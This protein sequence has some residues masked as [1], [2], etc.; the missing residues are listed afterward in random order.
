ASQALAAGTRAQQEM[1]KLRNDLRNQTSSQFAEQMRQMRN[2]ARELANKEDEI[3]R[4]MESLN[5]PGR[6]SLD[7]SA[8]RKQVAE[9]MDNQQQAL[10]NLLSNMQSVSQQAESTEPLLSQQLYDTLRHAN[11]LHTD[12]LLDAGAQM[13]ERGLLPQAAEAESAARTNI[14]E[15]RQKIE[16]AAESVLGN[17]ADTL[18]YAQKELDDLANRLERELNQGQP[19]ASGTARSKMGAGNS[20]EVA[21]SQQ[22]NGG[23]KSTN[24]QQTAQSSEKN[25]EKGTNSVAE[26]GSRGQGRQQG[27]GKN[28]ASRGQGGQQAGQNPQSQ[29]QGQANT[30][31]NGNRAGQ[32]AGNSNQD[33]QRDNQNNR[34]GGS[35]ENPQASDQQTGGTGDNS[36]GA[37]TVAGNDAE[38]LSEIVRQVGAN[39]GRGGLS[40]G[41]GGPITGSD[42]LDWT[43]R[44]RDV[45]QVLDTP[46][47][48]SQLATARERLVEL[49]AQYRQSHIKPKTELVRKQILDP[50]TE[51]RTQLRE[52]LARLSNEKSLVPLDH[53]PVPENYSE[54]VRKYYEKLGDGR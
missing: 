17:E 32:Q 37:T 38:R 44:M 2:Q 53:D 30:E 54:L 45:E 20:Q 46:E 24:S 21:Q 5:N 41:P 29:G 26:N 28:N 16:R 15:L 22:N 39:T 52:D 47:M 51:V 36:T 35:G 42:F 11:Q 31:A 33:G 1:E 40:Y 13:V 12:N 25:G 19:N 18:R 23:E 14:N 8:Q 50:I 27:S 49:R 9:Q 34:Q 43:S 7:D 48:R 6:K 3:A 10:T 4:G